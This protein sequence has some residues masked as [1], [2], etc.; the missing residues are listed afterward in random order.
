MEERRAPLSKGIKFD[1]TINLGN[2]LAVGG[3]VL[4]VFFAWATLDK[5]VSAVE[6]LQQAQTLRYAQDQKENKDTVKD[7]DR[8]LEKITDRIL[9]KTPR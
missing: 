8:K 1:P 4:S 5:R 9:E 3:C 2:V 7:I 6:L